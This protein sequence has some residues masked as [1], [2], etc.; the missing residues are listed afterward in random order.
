MVCKFIKIVNCR[1]GND[2]C[3]R[4]PCISLGMQHSGKSGPNDPNPDIFHTVTPCTH[5]VQLS[6]LPMH[7]AEQLAGRIP[8]SHLL[9]IQFEGEML[10]DC[11]SYDEYEKWFN[12][13]GSQ[14]YDN[15]LENQL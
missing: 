9:K 14:N 4:A 6:K 3:I 12:L 7:Q 15:Y 8:N 5:G 10:D 11:I 1:H 13:M 2:V